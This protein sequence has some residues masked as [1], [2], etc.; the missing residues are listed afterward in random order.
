MDDPSI[1]NN[2]AW[3]KERYDDVVSKLT[4]FLKGCG[5]NPQ[6]DLAFLPI[7]ALT[8]GNVRDK[9]APEICDWWGGPSLFTVL[10][11]TEPPQ[12][13]AMASFRMPI[14]DKYK[15]MG[16]V[17]MGKSESGVIQVRC[18]HRRPRVCATLACRASTAWR[19][20]R[21]W[22]TLQ[23][24]MGQLHALRDAPNAFVAR[25]RALHAKLCHSRVVPC[26]QGMGSS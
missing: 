10:D 11:N 21:L 8:A 4:P 15:D 5:F 19:D 12:R 3:S 24:C 16:C 14:M 26:R 6:R 2:G 23:V 17:V 13:D 22:S 25:S 18:S 9:P 1:S 20:G 7:A